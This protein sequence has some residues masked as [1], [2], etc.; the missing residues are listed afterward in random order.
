MWTRTHSIVTKKVTA[1]QMW[2][3]FA[4]VNNW[5][6]WDTGIGCAAM[7]GA[8][9]QGNHFTLKPKGGPKVKMALVEIIPNKRFM[10]LTQFPSAKM[11]GQHLLEETPDGLKITT[12]M[13]VGGLLGFLWIKLVAQDIVD[14]QP[15][16]MAAQVAFAEG[17]QAIRTRKALKGRNAL[18]RR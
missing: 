1:A 10:D 16:E 2:K 7:E 5:H 13:K 15:G 9:R 14:S 6:K 18:A 8:F 3:L 4:D 11:Y 17:L 12:T